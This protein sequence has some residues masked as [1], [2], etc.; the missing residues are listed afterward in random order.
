MMKYIDIDTVVLDDVTDLD[1]AADTLRFFRIDLDETPT[2]PDETSFYD[3]TT[4]SPDYLDI[5]RASAAR[6]CQIRAARQTAAQHATDR[7]GA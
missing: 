2:D 3:L 4:P 1:E 5:Q 7:R 6:R